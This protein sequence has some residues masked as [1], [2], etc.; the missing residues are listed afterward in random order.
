MADHITHHGAHA[1]GLAAPELVTRPHA[2][3]APPGATA[4]PPAELTPGKD[5]AA[6]LG[7]EGGAG[8]QREADGPDCAAH[9]QPAQPVDAKRLATLRATLAL[10]GWTLTDSPGNPHGAFIATRWAMARD[11]RDLDDVAAFARR[12]G[13]VR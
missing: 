6:E 3:L 1:P 13:A 4:A 2:D 9:H 5:N 12:V 8:G 10:A 11:L 7:S